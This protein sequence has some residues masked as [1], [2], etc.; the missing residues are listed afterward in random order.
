MRGPKEA[1]EPSLQVS[2][3]QLPSHQPCCAAS[4]PLERVDGQKV[5]SVKMEQQC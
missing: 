3:L 1:R 4:Y 2:C 5:L